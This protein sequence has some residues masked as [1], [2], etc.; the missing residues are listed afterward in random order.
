M[1]KLLLA[2]DVLLALAAFV[3]YVFRLPLWLT[4]L[5]IVLFIADS[6]LYYIVKHRKASH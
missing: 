2:L 6:V 1:K 5:I 3:M 4:G